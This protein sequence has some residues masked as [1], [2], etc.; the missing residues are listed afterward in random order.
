M[1]VER[2]YLWR[3]D[4]KKVPCG[5]KLLS[6]HVAVLRLKEHI[7]DFDDERAAAKRACQAVFPQ[8]VLQLRLVLCDKLEC[9]LGTCKR[10][11]LIRAQG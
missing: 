1:M 4:V 7:Q 10:Q 2:L 11:R 8:E 5:G 6:E 3:D 9:D